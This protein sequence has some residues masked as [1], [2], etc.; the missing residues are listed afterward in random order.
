MY[1]SVWRHVKALEASGAVTAKGD[2]YIV[3][4]D[5]LRGPAMEER[6]FHSAAYYQR[7]LAELVRLGLDA[8]RTMPYFVARPALAG[9]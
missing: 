4:T 5:Y 9:C 1:P 8:S 6:V 7:R 2:G 3:S